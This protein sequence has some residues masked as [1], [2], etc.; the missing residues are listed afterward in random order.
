MASQKQFQSKVSEVTAK[1]YVTPKPTKEPMTID[2]A[3]NV[4]DRIIGFINNCDNKASIALAGT[5]AI[6]AI[7]FSSD[8]IVKIAGIVSAILFPQTTNSSAGE[9]VYLVLLLLSMALLVVG[10]VFLVLVI[11]A[12][13][14]ADGSSAI[15]FG[16]IAQ[17]KDA[18]EYRTRVLSSKKDEL[19]TDI[20]NQIYI[21]SIIC[22]RKYKLYNQGLKYTGIGF[23]ALIT[24]LA[25]GVFWF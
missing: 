19:L 3:F 6:L 25:I 14:K 10:L 12:R 17:L 13:T 18:M 9:V 20:L 23:A 22:S 5:M 8:G 4:L 7:I 2:E 11:V 15:F 16:H 24:A 1:Q 21:N